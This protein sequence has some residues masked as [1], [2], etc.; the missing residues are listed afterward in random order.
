MSEPARSSVPPL[1][2]RNEPGIRGD[3]PRA[4]CDI[5]GLD[6]GMGATDE[7]GVGGIGEEGGEIESDAGELLPTSSPTA[8]VGE[9]SST[10]GLLLG[11]GDSQGFCFCFCRESSGGR[12]LSSESR[13]DRRSSPFR[14]SVTVPCPT[15]PDTMSSVWVATLQPTSSTT[16][17][18][19]AEE[20]EGEGEEGACSAPVDHWIIVPLV[21][22]S[23]CGG[24]GR[25]SVLR[26]RLLRA[27]RVKFSIQLSPWTAAFSVAEKQLGQHGRRGIVTRGVVGSEGEEARV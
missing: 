26:L 16:T 4:L 19:K 2:T 10:D 14:T 22:W 8:S 17:E 15:D 12:T 11:I 9:R 27:G 25:L 18:R 24:Q 20:E 1:G 21:E 6:V 5:V 3:V 7:V 13:T 23:R